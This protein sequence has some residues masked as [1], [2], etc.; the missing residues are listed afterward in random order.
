MCGELGVPIAPH[1]SV[2]P[3]TCITFL[4]IEVDTR[5]LALRLPREKLE[6][7]K[8]M[9][10]DWRGGKCCTKR[11]LESLA[12]HLCH[13]CEVVRPGRRFLRGLFDLLA[14][15]KKHHHI[16]RLNQ[17]FRGDIE[18]W[19]VFLRGWKGVSMLYDSRIDNPDIDIWSDA[20]GSWG[21][22]ALWNKKWF[23]VSWQEIPEFEKAPIAAKELLP[24]LMAVVL[25]GK[26]WGGGGGM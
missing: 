12:G 24:I 21:C 9:V 15:T 5:A 10:G 13:A 6:R 23:Q 7:L 8:Q 3:L 26:H 4:G 11:D 19:H 22:G 2:G 20:S 14:W 1:K 25:W 17:Q 16:V 18:W